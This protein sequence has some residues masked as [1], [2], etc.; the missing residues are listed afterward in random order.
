MGRVEYQWEGGREGWSC[1]ERRRGNRQIGKKKKTQSISDSALDSSSSSRSPL[2]LP[3]VI[4]Y[5]Y[6]I[7]FE[8]FLK[9][10][11]DMEWESVNHNGQGL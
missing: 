2:S 7:F 5:L 6:I 3:R 9:K 10:N 4:F 8:F 1:S 11:I